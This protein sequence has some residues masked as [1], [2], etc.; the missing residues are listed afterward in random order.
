[1]I[2]D[3]HPQVLKKYMRI[4]SPNFS[5]VTAASGEEGLELFKEIK[6][7][8]ILCDVKMP[9][10]ISGL[11]VCKAVKLISPQTIVVLISSYN[12]NATRKEGLSYRADSYIDK[13]TS[14]EEILLSVENLYFTMKNIP[15][16]LAEEKVART[17]RVDSFEEQAREIIYSFYDCPVY[18]RS[19]EK[20]SIK[21]FIKKSVKSLRT[22]QREF[23]DKTGY[24]F[25]EFHNR[26]RI[27]IACKLLIDTKKPILEISEEL[28]FG[29]PSAFSKAFKAA[30]GLTPNRYRSNYVL[31]I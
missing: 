1:M 27:E 25:T 16:S 11:E 21:L 13:L 12:N 5:C 8:I 14:E 7:E 26:I 18:M 6:P 9:S 28:C 4:F 22:L 17:R 23:L 30:T 15:L 10:G 20:L 2:I 31:S 3:D 29:T 19:E 24:T